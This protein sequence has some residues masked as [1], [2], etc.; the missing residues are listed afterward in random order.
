MRLGYS[1]GGVDSARAPALATGAIAIF[2]RGGV[3][4]WPLQRSRFQVDAS[5]TPSTAAARSD[6][7]APG[8]YSMTACASPPCLCPHIH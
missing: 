1:C 6:A 4:R 2:A 7:A 8:F 3:G 5:S